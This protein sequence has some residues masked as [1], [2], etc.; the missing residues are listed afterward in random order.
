[1]P[2]DN[3]TLQ[4]LI[5]N[6]Q[7]DHSWRKIELSSIKSLLNSEKIK[8][9]PSTRNSLLRS[10]F[11]IL[12]AHWE[13]FIK[14]SASHYLQHISLQKYKNSELSYGFLVL[15]YRSHLS[16]MESG[17]LE[18]RKEGISQILENLSSRSKVPYKGIID[19]KSNLRFHV[20]KE[21][22]SIIEIDC[23]KYELKG[24]LINTHLVDRRNSIAHGEYLEFDLEDFETIY[25]AIISIMEDFKEDIINAASSKK[26]LK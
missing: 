4:E 3:R 19:S 9:N 13:G 7:Q 11:T 8:K 12:Y 25:E 23:Q 6:I 16:D 5:D 18:K 10:L 2:K 14:S 21:I 20:F 26:Y 17:L 24:T 1:M 22:C 15:S